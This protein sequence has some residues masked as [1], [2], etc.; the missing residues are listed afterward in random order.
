MKTSPEIICIAEVIAKAEHLDTLLNIFKELKKL[1][2]Q[3]PGCI[4][5]ELHQSRDNPFKFTFVDRFKDQAAF[6]AHCE[7]DYVKHYFD[8]VIP[9]LTDHLSFELHNELI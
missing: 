5:Y 6:D 1:S 4:R 7:M 3:E 8:E 9:S 2:P